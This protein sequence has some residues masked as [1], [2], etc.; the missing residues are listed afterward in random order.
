[1]PA[2]YMAVLFVIMAD[3]VVVCAVMA[4][5]VMAYPRSFGLHIY[6]HAGLAYAAIADVIGNYAVMAY[7]VM[8]HAGMSYAA[9][10]CLAMVYVVVAYVVMAYAG[11]PCIGMTHINSITG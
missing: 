11:M 2:A 3:A 4:Y 5:V 1:M 9:V 8:A 6:G 10:A 7:E